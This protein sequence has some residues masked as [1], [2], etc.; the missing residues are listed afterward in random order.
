MGTQKGIRIA[1][2]EVDIIPIMDETSRDGL[3]LAFPDVVWP[4]MYVV[5]E[6]FL[7]TEAGLFKAAFKCRDDVLQG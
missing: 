2:G 4:F 7:H 6:T 3:V 5:P 1:C